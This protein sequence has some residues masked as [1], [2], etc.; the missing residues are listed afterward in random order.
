MDMKVLD[1][2]WFTNMFGCV[3]IAKV[4]DEYE[5]IKY[6]ISQVQGWDV[7]I[8]TKRVMEWGSVFP[9]DAGDVLFGVM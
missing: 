2:L 7:D 4:D 8:D 3:G 9:K 5:G 1:I 6:F